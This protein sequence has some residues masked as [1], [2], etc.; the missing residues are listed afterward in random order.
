MKDISRCRRC[1]GALATSSR[2]TVVKRSSARRGVSRSESDA[3][4][5]SGAATTSASGPSPAAASGAFPARPRVEGAPSSAS[6]SALSSARRSLKPSS[7]KKEK[8]RPLAMWRA[9]FSSRPIWFSAEA[10]A[11]LAARSS[12]IACALAPTA[13]DIR[14]D[15]AGGGASWSLSNIS[16][17]ADVRNRTRRARTLLARGLSPPAPASEGPGEGLGCCCCRLPSSATMFR[18]STRSNVLSV[19]PSGL[20]GSSLLLSV[21]VAR[22]RHCIRALSACSTVAT[23]WPSIAMSLSPSWASGSAR[24]RSCVA[25]QSSEW[26]RKRSLIGSS[27][28]SSKTGRPVRSER[29]GSHST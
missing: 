23:G 20:V 25:Y 16:A 29:G 15:G 21:S 5:A 24:R 2:M 10:S 9:S 28:R 6:T 11:S 22:S 27:E 4:A 17:F 8:V 26:R 18:L 12:A 7:C 19:L 1:E 14:S 13:R 3:A